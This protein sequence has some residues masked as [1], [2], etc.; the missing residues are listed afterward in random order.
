MHDVILIGSGT[1]QVIRILYHVIR[2]IIGEG[3]GQSQRCGDIRQPVDRV[4]AISILAAVLG[5]HLRHLAVQ[6]HLVGRNILRRVR[7][8]GQ[9]VMLV[10]GIAGHG[11]LG[12][13]FLYQVPHDI[14]L[15]FRNQAVCVLTLCQVA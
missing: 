2:R 3:P 6:I 14:I 4:V 1:V 12:G 15:V 10:I 11:S 7:D 5:R 13:D 9:F 8:T